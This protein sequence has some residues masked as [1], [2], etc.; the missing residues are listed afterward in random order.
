MR[1]PTTTGFPEPVEKFRRAMQARKT[2]TS[3][4]FRAAAEQLAIDL[5]SQRPTLEAD[6]DLRKLVGKPPSSS[7][8]HRW[9]GGTQFSI[10][11]QDQCAAISIW[12]TGHPDYRHMT[13]QAVDALRS[14]ILDALVMLRSPRGEF[15]A[16]LRRL[17]TEAETAKRVESER[18]RELAQLRAES[19]ARRVEMETIRA[20]HERVMVELAALRPRQR[21]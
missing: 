2:R 16:R 9:T 18:D 4:G 6:P 19:E 8:L 11:D 3:L 17:E 15:K 1:R 7:T 10:F 13:P 20:Q 5:A 14:E 21:V 12:L